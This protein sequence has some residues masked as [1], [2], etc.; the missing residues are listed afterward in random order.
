ME[1]RKFSRTL[2]L[3]ANDGATHSAYELPHLTVHLREQGMM[4][5][6]VIASQRHQRRKLSWD[7][8]FD[9]GPLFSSRGPVVRPGLVGNRV[10]DRTINS[11]RHFVRP[12]REQISDLAKQRIGSWALAKRPRLAVRAPFVRLVS[13]F[14]TVLVLALT[15]TAIAA[16]H[17]DSVCSCT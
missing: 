14:L 4:I 10:V 9:H 13:T 7:S 15:R 11:R 17:R 3:A 12:V 6:P 2:A 8:G 16:V 1:K 5:H